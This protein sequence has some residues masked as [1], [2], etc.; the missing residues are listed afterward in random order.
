MESCNASGIQQLD[1]LEEWPAGTC[2]VLDLGAQQGVLVGCVVE[3]ALDSIGQYG[4]LQGD[5]IALTKNID[6][7]LVANGLYTGRQRNISDGATILEGSL[8][9]GG[10]FISFLVEKT[11]YA[12]IALLSNTEGH[13]RVSIIHV[14]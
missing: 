11:P 3:G 10:S 12:L 14:Y 1:V 2:E 4:A 8:T 6:E 5:G 9:N 7:S 13:F